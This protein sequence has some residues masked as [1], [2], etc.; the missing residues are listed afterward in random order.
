MME[1]GISS[2]LLAVGAGLASVISPCVLPVIPIILA[3]AER[4][5]RIR[6][7]FLVLGLSISFMAMGAASS[8]FG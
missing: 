2:I 3:G 1:F 5:D 4:K 7:L 6:P 8:L